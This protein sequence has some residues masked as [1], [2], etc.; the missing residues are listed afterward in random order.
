MNTK[1]KPE[2]YDLF[3]KVVKNGKGSL[4]ERFVLP[5]FS[6]LDTR[7]GDWQNRKRKWVELG[8]RSELGRGD[9]TVQTTTTNKINEKNR[10]G[11][12]MP[13]NI[14]S[15]KYG[16]GKRVG[17][18]IF[19]PVLCELMYKWFSVRGD[20][21]IDPFSGG[22]VRGIVA[23]YLNRNYNG[24]DLRKEQIDANIS[25]FREMNI[26][27]EIP[28]DAKWYTGD[29]SELENILPQDLQ[30]DFIF[31]CP[32]YADLEKYSDDPKDLSNMEYDKFLEMYRMVIK[33]AVSRLKEDRFAVYVVSEV[34]N[35]KNGAY[36]GFVKD[37]ID[38]FMDVGMYYY[39]EIILVNPVGS[40]P[41]RLSHSFNRGR[42][43]GKTHQ[44]VLVFYRGN[45]DNI[46]NRYKNFD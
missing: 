13:E 41:I 4:S 2:Q 38:A 15:D 16:K 37:T 25:Q 8:I 24:I 23:S 33:K 27:N 32:P 39:N 35:K 29:S 3:G 7:Q 10:Y 1:N 22:S 5:P 11:K 28:G 36:R 6:I 31:S 44:N 34:R 26:K 45:I 42:K 40:L 17:I 43:I 12:S 30:G 20:T 46:K 19:D 9:N 21:V 14:W 18:S